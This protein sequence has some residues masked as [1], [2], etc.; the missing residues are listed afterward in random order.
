[1]EK[2]HFVYKTYLKIPS[3]VADPENGIEGK[4]E[5]T[6]EQYNSFDIDRVIR[7][8]TVEDKMLFQNLLHK[9]V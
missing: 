7:V 2:T 8:I 5:E 6:I 4:D 3:V 1:M 9:N